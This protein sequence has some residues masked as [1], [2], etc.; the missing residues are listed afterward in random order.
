MRDEAAPS[1]R[2]RLV[3]L[4]LN[5]VAFQLLYGACSAAAARAGVV[6]D[7]ATAWDAH[8]PFLPWMLLPY[9]SSAPLLASAFLLVPDAQGLRALSQ[10]L[11]L[12]TALGTLVFALFPLRFAWPRPAVDAGLPAALAA[13]LGRV[14]APYN[15]LPSLHVAYCVIVWPALSA[16]LRSTP[17][18]AALA[19]GLALVAASTLFTWQHHLA[20]LPAGALLGALAWRAVPAR[21][22]EPAV[23]LHYAVL[24]LAAATL[25]LTALPLVPALW[26]AACCAAV[27]L[28]YARG[29]AGFLHK[30]G[31]RFPAWVRL[32]YGPY[33]LG[34]LATWHLVRWRERNRPALEPFCEGVWVGRRLAAHEVGA[35]P[36]D[37]AV[38]DLAS[39]LSE[40]PALRARPG[41]AFALFDLLQA[42][43]ARL[44]RILDAIDAQRALGRPVYVHCAMGYRRSREVVRAWRARHE[45]P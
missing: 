45:Q 10:R 44:A 17:A 34:Y 12:A 2:R 24:A 25:G 35:L 33:L 22:D 43:T 15:Q 6:R 7:V 28:A 5:G 26:L 4:A 36:A 29:D 42:P 38:I 11:L 16:R 19:A 40:A 14:D 8:V 18:R 9:M 20:D 41:A 32:L 30:R 31:G 1:L 39:E 37:A 3:L 21:R 23:A 13:L 27:A